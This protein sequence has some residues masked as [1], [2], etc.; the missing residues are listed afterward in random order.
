MSEELT[1][2]QMDDL[3]DSFAMFDKNGDGKIS[4]KELFMVMLTVEDCPT[5]QQ[6]ER[7]VRCMDTDGDGKISFNEYLAVMKRYIRCISWI[8]AAIAAF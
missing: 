1:K 3:V 7:I 4:P 8:L 5:K 6:V 2:K